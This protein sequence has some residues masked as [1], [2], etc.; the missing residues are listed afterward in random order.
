M[1]PQRSASD[2]LFT[3]STEY[4][5]NRVPFETSKPFEGVTYE[6]LCGSGS[7]GKVGDVRVSFPVVGFSTRVCTG[8]CKKATC[9]LRGGETSIETKSRRVLGV[10]SV[11][12]TVSVR[13]MGIWA[14]I[15][16]SRGGISLPFL[17][18]CDAQFLGFC[19]C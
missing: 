10:G 3:M 18:G 14:G 5:I 1:R 8:A 9:R 13:S 4:C 7:L 12:E 16:V 2:V 6:V 17:R 15:P 19:L 11:G